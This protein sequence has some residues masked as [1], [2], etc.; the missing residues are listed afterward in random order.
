[1]TTIQKQQPVALLPNVVSASSNDSQDVRFSPV[2]N[3]VEPS[4]EWVDVAFAA[5]GDKL[6]YTL[7]VQ[8][9]GQYTVPKG[10]LRIEDKVPQGSILAPQSLLQANRLTDLSVSADGQYFVAAASAVGP[11]DGWRWLRW[12]YLKPLAPGQSFSLSF[13]TT[14]QEEVVSL[15]DAQDGAAAAFSEF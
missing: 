15:N 10:H 4:Y 12:A 6:Q 2:N 3:G 11:A 1:M 5:S 14:L 9:D 13:Q 7:K 8:N